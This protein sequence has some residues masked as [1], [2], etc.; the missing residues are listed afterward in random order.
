MRNLEHF[1]QLKN[2]ELDE[3]IFS[4]CPNIDLPRKR[5]NKMV[6]IRDINFLKNKMPILIP[7]PELAG[8]FMTISLDTF[9][10]GEKI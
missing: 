9:M 8:Q 6:M 10:Q 4:F 7:H 3:Y 2:K 5:S 1:N